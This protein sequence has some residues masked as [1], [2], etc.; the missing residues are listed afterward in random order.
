M[1]PRTGSRDSFILGVHVTGPAPEEDAAL[2]A[3]LKE[4]ADPADLPEN[5]EDAAAAKKADAKDMNVIVV[6]DIDW[7]IPSFFQI[8]DVGGEDFLP[9]TQ[10]VTFILNIMDELAGDDRFMDIRKRARVYRTL[11]KIDE[12]TRESREKANMDE[13]KFIEEIT[14]QEQE[15]RAEMATK[16][17]QVESRT[18][19][20]SLEKDVLLEQVRMRA[21]GELEAKVRTMAS[22]RRRKLKEI[23]YDLDQ[24][25]RT[26]Q[27][28]YKLF[29]ILI[30]PIPPLLLA[31]AV[32]FRR[33][34][35]ERQGVARE[36][37]R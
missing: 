34:E 15:A 33:R 21:Q 30:P 29:A 17:D 32:F 9:A 31:L 11:A 12:A 5:A 19:L 3:P 14:K 10:N 2:A 6:S 28:K 36:R 13:E 8:R 26:V 27:D 23:E 25:I 24:K 22:D 16:I 18:D 7:I 20:N 37:L 1:V 4:G 35:L